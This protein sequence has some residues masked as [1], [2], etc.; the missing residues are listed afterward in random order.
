MKFFVSF[1]TTLT[2]FVPLVFAEDTDIAPI[3]IDGKFDD[4]TDDDFVQSMTEF[5]NEGA[6]T[7][8]V[9]GKLFS[10]WSCDTGLLCLALIMNE[11]LTIQTEANGPWILKGSDDGLLPFHDF[12]RIGKIGWEGCIK[13][14]GIE[15]KTLRVTDKFTGDGHGARS[16]SSGAARQYITLRC[17][18]GGGGDP[19]FVTYDGTHYAYHGACDMIFAQ[20]DSFGGGLGLHIHVRTEINQDWSLISNVAVQIG[21]EVLEVLQ[22]GS[23]YFN[24]VHGSIQEA[25]AFMAHYQVRSRA[26]CRGRNLAE[27]GCKTH[28]FFYEIN[29]GRGEVIEITSFKGFVNVK[30]RS[31]IDNF[32]GLMGTSG[33]VGMIDRTG[34]VISDPIQMGPAWQVRDVDPMLFHDVRAPQYPEPCILPRKNA[35]K[36]LLDSRDNAWADAR[37]RELGGWVH[38]RGRSLKEYESLHL[39]AIKAC[40]GTKILEACIADIMT[41]GDLDMAFLYVDESD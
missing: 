10:R 41:T 26:K 9:V 22:D 33:K 8:K 24:G 32:A 7:G 39:Q 6:D 5:T 15:E 18:S 25:P 11:G 12:K 13:M 19:H 3:V 38:R 29:L 4:W 2:L 34:E 31:P 28:K 40:Q 30:I 20:S 21:A 14:E 27:N 16:V 23:H 35:V 37:R 36:S 1:L 17:H